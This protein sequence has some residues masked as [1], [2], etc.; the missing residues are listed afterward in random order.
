MCVGAR[1]SMVVY[2]CV[3]ASMFSGEGAGEG[4]FVISFVEREHR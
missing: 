3:C 4:G 1:V 2:V